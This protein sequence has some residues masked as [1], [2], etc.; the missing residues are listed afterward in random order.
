MCEKVVPYELTVFQHMVTEMGKKIHTNTTLSRRLR[1]RKMD[2]L[3]W[4][5]LLHR[6]F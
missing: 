5:V 6:T 1:A 2:P 3:P 4:L